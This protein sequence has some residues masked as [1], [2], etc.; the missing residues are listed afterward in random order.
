MK[1]NV[2]LEKLYFGDVDGERE[3]AR[4]DF[5]NLFYN[6]NDKYN[7]ILDGSKFL[8]I[9]K[10]GSG[11][12]YLAKYICLKLNER[13]NNSCKIMDS[14]NF[15]LQKLIDLSGRSFQKGEAELFWKWIILLDFSY[16]IIKRNKILK[17]IPFTK[18]RKLRKFIND[19]Y[20]KK[21]NA[22]KKVK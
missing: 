22:F 10:K 16:E 21:E 7:D 12:T 1:E 9:G 17:Y 20:P 6:N 13:K 2:K 19:K 11:K 14:S 5:K 18:Y 3:A 4:E 8:I 15:N